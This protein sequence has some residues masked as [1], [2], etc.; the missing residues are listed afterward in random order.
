MAGN[1]KQC[2]CYAEG[3]RLY[4]IVDHKKCNHNVSIYS[5]QRNTAVQLWWMLLISFFFNQ[6]ETQHYVVIINYHTMIETNK[7][8]WCMRRK[9]S[10][11]ILCLGRLNA[12]CIPTCILRCVSHLLKYKIRTVEQMWT[13]HD[14]T[15]LAYIWV[16]SERGLP[17]VL[18]V[19]Q[20][21][22]GT[23]AGRVL[24]LDHR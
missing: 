14:L 23:L 18:V 13:V 4:N 22:V 12:C 8:Y 17:F 3:V 9:E 11:R 24:G 19:G 2:T 5:M 7:F 10:E 6:Q 1:T 15:G 20:H 16:W 21:G